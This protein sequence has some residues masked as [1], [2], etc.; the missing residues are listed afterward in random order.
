[1][2]RRN[3]NLLIL[4]FLFGLVSLG[5]F[6]FF[7]GIAHAQDLH[8]DLLSDS[9]KVGW[10]FTVWKTMLGLANIV[11]V[12]ILVALAVI[13][14]LHI[15]YDT[16]AIKKSLPLLILG[17][18]MAYFS[19][20]ICRM[21]VDVAQVL[22]NTFAGNTH[23]LAVNYLCSIAIKSNTIADVFV[24]N[25]VFSLIVIVLFTVL[26]LIAILILSFLL[27]VRKYVIFVLVAIAPLAF[28]LYAFPPTQGLF[29][30]WWTEF[31]K[32]VFMGPVIMFIMYVASQIGAGNCNNFSLPALLAVI[33]LTYI[34][35]LVPFKL[36]G[37]VMGAWSKA[38]KKGAGLAG[39]AAWNNPWAKAQ[40]AKGSQKFGDYWNRTR[41]GQSVNRAQGREKEYKQLK[42]EQ[43]K[44]TVEAGRQSLSPRERSQI[45]VQRRTAQYSTEISESNRAQLANA[46]ESGQRV[47][48]LTDEEYQ[49]YTGHASPIEAAR[50]FMNQTNDLNTAKQ[51]LTK[52]RDLDIGGPSIRDLRYNSAV[53][54][55]M[56]ADLYQLNADGSVVRDAA[57]NGVVLAGAAH[58]VHGISI[59][60]R[61]SR[62]NIAIAAGAPGHNTMVTDAEL[63]NMAAEIRFKAKNAADPADQ[64]RLDAAAAEYEEQINTY[65]GAQPARYD[66]DVLL[67]RNLVGRKYSET[68]KRLS[69]EADITKK[70]YTGHN[71]VAATRGDH[72]T[73]EY[74]STEEDAHRVYLGR[75][76]EVEET[77]AFSEKQHLIAIDAFMRE[78]ERGDY[79]GVY[80][81]NDMITRIQ[82]AHDWDTATNG[83]AVANVRWDINNAALSQLPHDQQDSARNQVE[84]LYRHNHG[85]AAGTVLTVPQQADA[86]ET[87]NLTQLKIDSSDQ[88]RAN[89]RMIEAVVSQIRNRPGVGLNE[90]IGQSLS[91]SQANARP[92]G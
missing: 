86:L 52:R 50:A 38:G 85:I 18:I 45:E 80:A 4:I 44:A 31:L 33:G 13:N 65:E 9:S 51:A 78:A 73:S 69:E 7:P 87:L 15:Q 34:A 24:A 43:K 3:K 5:A 26:I 61:D 67:D 30:K 62:G 12:L 77:A 48:G 46:L 74:R 8:T 40:R 39:K 70:S 16:Y 32:W 79:E 66:Y 19:L 58:N 83:A 14:I 6:L 21:I 88:G 59:N 75:S 36:G 64:A 41:L 28:I 42:E 17:I 25:P 20:F 57:G 2:K 22:T 35:A 92:R 54:N 53:N 71:I 68:N 10:I 27:L 49:R 47:P 81:T 63:R 72:G 55:Q 91:R 23:D 11:V 56:N 60:R 84:D 89:Q 29:K 37:A 76:A 1:M 90:A 82:E